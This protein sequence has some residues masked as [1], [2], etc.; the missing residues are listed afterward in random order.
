M[1]RKQHVVESEKTP[2]SNCRE[3]NPP[4]STIPDSQNI[5]PTVKYSRRKRYKQKKRENSTDKHKV[6]TTIA[7]MSE[8]VE[9]M[10]IDDLIK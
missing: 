10:N 9:G 3:E 6:E 5:T 1:Q 8:Q 7:N 4:V 2:T